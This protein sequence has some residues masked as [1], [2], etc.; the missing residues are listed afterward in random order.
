[1][2]KNCLFLKGVNPW[3]WSKNGLFS[4]FFVLSIYGRK[5]CIT[6]FQNEKTP[7][8]AIK[9]R[10][11]IVEKLTFFQKGLTHRFGPKITI[12][13]T[14]LFQVIQACKMSFTI[15]CDE[16]TPF[17]DIRT[18]SSNRRKID[19][20][21]KKLTHSFAPKMAIFLPFF[22]VGNVGQENVF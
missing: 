10:S 14:F 18:R 8:Q 13:P 22:F 6:I 17:Q 12:F 19:I 15:F 1:M 2:S 4:N 21:P 5:T 20:F 3:F 16:K 9:K 11:S 7:F